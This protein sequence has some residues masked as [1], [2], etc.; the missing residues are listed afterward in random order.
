VINKLQPIREWTDVTPDKFQAEIRPLGQ[1]AV[2]RGLKRDWPLVQ[3]GL[4]SPGFAMDYLSSFY[5]GKPVSALSAPPE[6]KGRFFYNKELNGYN[7]SRSS[8]NLRAILLA[9]LKLQGDPAAPAVAMQAIEAPDILPGF[10]AAHSME[11]APSVSPKLWIGNAA[12]VAP[13]YDLKENVACVAVGRRRFTLFP[14]E[15]ASNLY[16]GPLE[17]TPAGA[18]ISMVSLTE[19]DFDAYP[20]FRDALAAAQSG[21]LEPGDVIYIPYMWWHGVEALERFNVLVNYWW[22]DHEPRSRLHPMHAM[23][24]AWL[25]F[26]D[27]PDEHKRRWRD[28][29][30]LYI[31]GDGQAMEHL[32]NR[33]RGVLG[34]LNEQQIARVKQMLVEAIMEGAGT[35]T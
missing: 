10:E 15:Q 29:F 16:I 26:M 13:H 1:P 3:A 20:R 27:M 31:F 4:K 24:L 7:F 32:P 23:V 2:I 5:S 11:L 8:E 22:N 9:L 17:N 33:V 34:E 14:P 30:D 18:P 21:D 12:H 35:R 6:E 28:M 25:T 19:P